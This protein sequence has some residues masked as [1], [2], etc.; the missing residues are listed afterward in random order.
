[1]ITQ[2]LYALRRASLVLAFFAC[3]STQAQ[4]GQ[5]PPFKRIPTPAEP[6]AIPL[7]SGVAPGSETSK[8]VEV[9]DEIMGE[10]I[11]RNVTRPTL[12]PVLPAPGKANGSAVI[13]APGG[14]FMMISMDNEGYPVARALAD[15]GIA[16]FVLKYRLDA[17]PED[18][19]E[20]QAAADARLAGAAKAGADKVPPIHQPLATQDGLAALALVRARAREWNVDPNRVGMIGFSAGAMTVLQVTLAGDPVRRP[21]FVALIYGPMTPV[22]LPAKVPPAFIALAADDPLFGNS[23]FGIVES[24]KKAGAPVELHYYEKG[25]HGFGMRRLNTTSDLWIAQFEAWLAAR[26]LTTASPAADAGWVASWGSSPIESHIVIPGVPADKIP[27]SPIVRGTLRYRLPLSRAGSRVILRL[28]NEANKQP[29]SVGA[30][31]V[32]IADTGVNARPGTLKKVTFGGQSA[33]TIAGGAPALSDPVDLSNSAEAVIVS[34]YLPNDT[35]FALGQMRMQAVSLAGRDATLLPVIEGASPT[36]ARTPVSAILVAGAPN[37]HT[38]VAFGDSITD[39]GFS[40]TP[41]VRGWPGHLSRRLLQSSGGAR[42]AVANQGIA[43]NRI[44]SDVIGS[45]ALSRF[46]RDVLS[47]PNV[48]HVILLEGINDI[49]FARL[50]D[51]S[52]PGPAVTSD[53]LIAG[54]RQLIARA[55][56][57]GIKMVGGTLLPFQGAMYYS[58]AGEQTRQAVNTWIRSGGEFD[59]V[60]DFDRALRDPAEPKKL[61]A[62]YDS[63]DHLHPS[64]AGFKAMAMAFTLNELGLPPQRP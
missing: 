33:L 3:A 19:K 23:G 55:H 51:N 21:D 61:A 24:W 37:S 20:F 52:S 63:G 22:K 7:Y 49:G 43:G 54:F 14:A 15:Q 1:M 46:D 17:T 45:S 48:S 56:Q 44:L 36:M 50:P 10:R 27:P 29:L 47:L 39:G 18:E 60:V 4:M 26:G 12:T 32:G 25:S 11:A 31:T 34:L 30:V 41:D 13:V 8:Q 6:N 58:E 42:I 38:I 16:A 40:G 9:W 2:H 5:M 64:D 59:A 35:E 28:T 57:Q 53:A 62:A